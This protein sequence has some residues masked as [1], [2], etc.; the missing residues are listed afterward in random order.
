MIKI[1]TIDNLY[2]FDIYHT[3]KIT[4]KLSSDGETVI[5]DYVND[6]YWVYVD[7]KPDTWHHTLKDAEKYIKNEYHEETASWQ[8]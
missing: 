1:K 4:P 2:R 7:D 6:E 8:K 3:T 5:G